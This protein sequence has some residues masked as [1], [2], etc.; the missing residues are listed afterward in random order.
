MRKEKDYFRYDPFADQQPWLECGK[1]LARRALPAGLMGFAEAVCD[2]DF[3]GNMA[4]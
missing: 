1:G 4:G 3:N 2:V